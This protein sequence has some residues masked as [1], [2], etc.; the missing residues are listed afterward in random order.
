MPFTECS[1]GPFGGGPCQFVVPFPLGNTK[2][3]VR[4]GD[5]DILHQI[6]CKYPNAFCTD[7]KS[8]YEGEHELVSSLSALRSLGPENTSLQ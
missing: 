5:C 7:V 6:Q 1:S 2:E 4:G 8:C 3:V